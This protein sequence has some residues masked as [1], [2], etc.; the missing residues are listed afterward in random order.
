MPIIKNNL[1]YELTSET[2]TKPVSA[3]KI[4]LDVLD[5]C[6]HAC[7]GC[8]VNRRNNSPSDTDMEGLASFVE[9]I[10]D[11]GILVDEIL[12]GP[13][14]FL[15][16]SNNYEVL[17]NKNL[18][19]VINKNS[20]ILAFVT[21]LISGDL[22]KFCKFLKDNINLDTEIEIGIATNPDELMSIM[23]YSMIQSKLK[24]LSDNIAHDITYTFIINI[25]DVDKNYEKLHQ[26]VVKQFDTTFDLVPSIAR[27]RNKVK[28]LDKI[29]GLNS[30][31]DKLLEGN[32]TNNI[33]VDHSHSGANFK[34][35]NFK[36]GEWW[37]SPFLYENMA[38][39]D[40]LF[41][42]NTFNDVQPMLEKQYKFDTECSTCVFL[43]SCTA[44][45]IPTL[46]KYLNTDKC[47]CPKEN[48]LNNM[49]SYNKASMEMYNWDDYT[50]NNDKEGYRKKFLIHDELSEDLVKI[51]EIYNGV[52]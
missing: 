37:V 47:I 7:N 24:F 1:Y 46:M 31:Y 16:S 23:Y 22:D 34:V 45:F 30:N 49:H 3:V 8:F 27:S 5:G 44:R 33:M 15:S 48:M 6:E 26:F 50:V 4:Q 38:I 10:T 28:I 51:K 42:I 39:Y 35:L 52:S 11:Q 9:S 40:D 13:T 17:S 20:P 19:E 14:D 36:K 12:I 43:T 2:K 29:T 21:T 18:L 25:D 41:K 32:D